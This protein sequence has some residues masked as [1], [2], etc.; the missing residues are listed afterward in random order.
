[1]K[2]G[3]D[4]SAGEQGKFYHKNFVLNLPI[5]L[6]PDVDRFVRNLADQNNK[7]VQELVNEWLRGGIQVIRSIE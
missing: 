2:K 7:D 1:M 4:F 6:E 5:Y 3:Y